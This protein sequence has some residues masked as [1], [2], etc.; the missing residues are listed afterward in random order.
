MDKDMQRKNRISLVGISVCL[1][2]IIVLVALFFYE[3]EDPETQKLSTH[4]GAHI[5]MLLPGQEELAEEFD[6][7]AKEVADKYDLRMESMSLSTVGA[8]QQMLS[9][10]PLTDV[11]GVLL[12]AVSSI[13]EDYAMELRDCR[14]AGIPV[15]MIDHDFGDKSLRNSFVG[16]G[17]N[18]ELMVI[19]QTLWFTEGNQPILIG[20]Y[21]HASSG[22]IYELLMMEKIENPDFRAEQIWSERLRA[23]VGEPPNEY[24]ASRYIQVRAADSGMAALNLELIRVLHEIDATG[25]VFSLDETLTRALA[26]AVENGILEKD[27]LGIVIGYGSDSE[28]EHY[29]EKDIVDELIVSDV[30]YSSKI[31]LRYLNDILR[32]FYVPSELDSG[33]KLI[34]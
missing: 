30:L 15:V 8:Q 6:A 23:F 32:G 21:S 22:D 20:T 28:L 14:D 3:R 7:A 18:S 31:G 13:D 33:V 2:A 16:S 5:L 19:N 1:L 4:N 9:L 17:M 27:R 26:A 34:T 11:D 10:V 12:W 24:Y 25:L 29:V